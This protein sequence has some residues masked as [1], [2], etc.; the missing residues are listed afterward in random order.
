MRRGSNQSHDWDDYYSDDPVENVK[1]KA[2]KFLIYLLIPI[3]TSIGF[4]VAGNINI[5]SNRSQEFGQGLLAT[6]ACD[7]NVTLIPAS[8][9]RTDTG[10]FYLDSITVSGVDNSSNGCGGEYFSIKAYDSTSA[11]PLNLYSVGGNTYNE[12]DVQVGSTYSPVLGGLLASDV[13]TINSSSFIA[14]INNSGASPRVPLA[15]SSNIYKFTIESKYQAFAG[16]L[17]FTA[18]GDEYLTFNSNSAYALGTSN[19]TIEW[20][21]KFPNTS[22]PSIGGFYDAGTGVNGTGDIAIFWEGGGQIKVRPNSG[23]DI[24]YSLNATDFPA[25]TWVHMAVVRNSNTYTLYIGGVDKAH[26]TYVSSFNFT[27][28]TPRIGALYDYP[29]Y[30]NNGYMSN[31]RVTK[32]A[33]YTSGFTPPTSPLSNLA[34]TVLLILSQT[35]DSAFTDLSSTGGTAVNTNIVWRSDHP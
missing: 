9:R 29:T 8:I 23:G 16:S 27:A 2:R 6:T 24:I 35:S 3:L 32:S 31:I 11:T 5:N 22:Y 28:A 1:V 30:S 18:S 20:F 10:L 14:V 13:T 4:T 21:Q 34:N 12:I 15:L 7:N 26:T 19:F 25:N 17:D 33:L